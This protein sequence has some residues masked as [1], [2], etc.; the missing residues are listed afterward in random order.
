MKNLKRTLFVAVLSIFVG[1]SMHA[2]E[3][4]KDVRKEM[5]NKKIEKQLAVEDAQEARMKETF[6]RLKAE[7]K[8]EEERAMIDKKQA[9]YEESR[10][11]NSLALE[12]KMKEQ[13]LKEEQMNKTRVEISKVDQLKQAYEETYALEQKLEANNLKIKEANERLEKAIKNQ[14]LSAEEIAEKQ[15]KLRTADKELQEAKKALLKQRRVI[16][17]K[18]AELDSEN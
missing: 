2:Q 15:A 9:A 6:K 17:E 3:K 8:S 10:S 4:T 5:Q 13:K 7:A 11:N 16:N 14:T 1:V 12:R 18:H